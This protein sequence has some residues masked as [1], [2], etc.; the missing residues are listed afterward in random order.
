MTFPE[1]HEIYHKSCKSFEMRTDLSSNVWKR[2]HICIMDTSTS[3]YI[4]THMDTYNG[5]V[6][7]PKSQ[8][9]AQNCAP[10]PA[11]SL[12]PLAQGQGA[13]AQDHGT[14]DRGHGQGPWP[15]A[16]LA[17][18]VSILCVY[19]CPYVH[20]CIHMYPYVS[21]WYMCPFV[22]MCFEVHTWSLY[23][24]SALEFR[25]QRSDFLC[26]HWV[27]YSSAFTKHRKYC[28]LEIAASRFP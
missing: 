9:V 15:R 28:N 20:K 1:N 22:S 8:A 27:C 11:R 23:L 3:M 12:G 21:I 26:K 25:T 4:W 5:Y 16:P 6:W 24:K 13:L 18:Y 7:G 10:G 2:M 19:V 17:P 14:L